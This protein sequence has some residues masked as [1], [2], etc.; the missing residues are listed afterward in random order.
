MIYNISIKGFELSD[1]KLDYIDNYVKKISRFL[2][3][4]DFNLLQFDI[5]VKK[6]KG[7][8]LDHG[9]GVKVHP[10]FKSAIY[11]ECRI[12]LQIPIKSLV[13]HSKGGSVEEAI[14]ISFDHLI[15]ELEKYEGKH[16]QNDSDYFDRNS[17]RR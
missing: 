15:K 12:W 5:I 11:Y 2:S 16:I 17:I 14:S 9:R 1:K 4:V 13:V 10:K 7:K 8:R 3:D 6:Y